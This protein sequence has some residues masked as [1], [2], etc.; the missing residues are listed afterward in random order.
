MTQL[1]DRAATPSGEPTLNRRGRASRS[2]RAQPNTHLEVPCIIRNIPTYDLLSE[3]R[4][5]MIE[6]AADT[7]LA[8]IGI[9]FR[10]DPETVALFHNAGCQ[11]TAVSGFS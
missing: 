8:E 9:E 4:L 1:L 2:A 11:V 7:I 5:G 6:Q 10:E 3:A